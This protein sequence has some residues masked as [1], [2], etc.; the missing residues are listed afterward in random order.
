MQY[1]VIG[2]WVQTRTNSKSKNPSPIPNNNINNH[3]TKINGGKNRKIRPKNRDMNLDTYSG[4]GVSHTHVYLFQFAQ[5]YRQPII[6]S[7]HQQRQSPLHLTI[8][9]TNSTLFIFIFNLPTR[10][11]NKS[12]SS[13]S[14]SFDPN[15]S[16]RWCL[17]SP[18]LPA[19]DE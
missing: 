13:S 12:I 10:L 8:A 7:I 4:D 17:T 1:T 16:P 11:P 3:K 15:K 19:T 5:Q 6:N 18:T 14:S 2:S 9:N